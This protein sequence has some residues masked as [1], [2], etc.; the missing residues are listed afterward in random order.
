M[1]DKSPTAKSSLEEVT[2]VTKQRRKQTAT[3]TVDISLES[4]ELNTY[5]SFLYA[6]SAVRLDVKYSSD[7]K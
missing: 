1:I 2:P 3:Y 7:L 5:N 4:V 6:L